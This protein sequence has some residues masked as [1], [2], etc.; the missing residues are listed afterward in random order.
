MKSG[1][2]SQVYQIVGGIPEGKVATYGQIAA[3]LGNPRG[4]R[5]VGWALH[6]NPYSRAVPCHRVV[7]RAGE[8]SGRFSFGDSEQ[9]RSLLEGEGVRF[10]FDGRVDLENH[11]WHPG[12]SVFRTSHK[13]RSI[14][15]FPPP[16][17][18]E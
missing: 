9:Q 8:L 17:G 1:Y 12:P 15:P 14:L 6:S 11:L 10:L 16:A 5:T 13:L 4:A 18:S 3:L 7:N 2:F